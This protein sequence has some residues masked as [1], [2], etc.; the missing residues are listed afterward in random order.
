MRCGFFLCVLCVCV[1]C[2][3]R[4][5]SSIVHRLLAAK[6]SNDSKGRSKAKATN[7]PIKGEDLGGYAR[8]P[9]DDSPTWDLLADGMRVCA[10]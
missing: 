7:W 9:S 8:V 4:F 2:L 6:Q 5:A 3:T 10:L 1:T